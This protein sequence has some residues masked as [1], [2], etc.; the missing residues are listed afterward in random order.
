MGK[1]GGNPNH[2]SCR[3]L[4]RNSGPNPKGGTMGDTKL[5]LQLR[6]QEL[7]RDERGYAV[8]RTMTESRTVPAPNTAI[9]ICDVWDRHWSRSAAERTV[10]LAARVNAVV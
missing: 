3:W 9:I 5:R 2:P 10:E 7:A 6:S 4:G 1:A 8:W